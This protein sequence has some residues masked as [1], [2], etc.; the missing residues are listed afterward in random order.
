M[1]QSHNATPDVIRHVV[2]ALD[3]LSNLQ[4]REQ[5]GWKML[6]EEVYLF[7]SSVLNSEDEDTVKR[8]KNILQRENL[9]ETVTK[10]DNQ[11]Y[12]SPDAEP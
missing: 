1:G 7:V 6:S 5:I 8:A 11:V 2:R 12:A 10:E 4:T 3:N 9:D